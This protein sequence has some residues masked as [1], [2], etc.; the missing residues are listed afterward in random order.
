MRRP[1]KGR[2]PGARLATAAETA[3]LDALRSAA[4]CQFSDDNE[5]HI[6][7]LQQLWDLAHGDDAKA[8]AF[9]RVGTEWTSFGFQRDDPVSDLRG[10]GVLALQNLVRHLLNTP[11]V[12]SLCA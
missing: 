9:V 12:A 2:T 8:P 11:L 6:A 4:T 10:G 5:G 3:V 7:L 1:G